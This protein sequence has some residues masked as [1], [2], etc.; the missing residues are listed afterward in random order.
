[1]TS[2]QRHPTFAE[3]SAKT[4][5]VFRKRPCLLQIKLCSAFLRGSKNIICSAATGFGKTLTFFMPLL[6]DPRIIIIITPLNV[7]GR[8]NVEQLKAA[9]IKAIS[10]SGATATPEVFS[11]IKAGAYQL[12]VTNPEVLMKGRGQFDRLFEDKKFTSK[13]MGFIADEAHCITKWGSFR[14][15]Y[16]ELG[17]LRYMLPNV[18]VYA[19]SATISQQ[20]LADLCDVLHL[21]KDNTEF[22][23]RS[24]DRLNVFYV[25]REMKHS[26]KSF[27]DLNFLI[28]DGWQEGNSPPAKFLVFFDNKKESEKACLHLKN[29]LPVA[30]RDKVQWFHANMTEK[31]REAQVDAMRSGETWGLC[32]T[33]SF[34]MG[35]DIPGIQLAVQYRLTCTMDSLMQPEVKHFDH[36][37]RRREEKKK[38][39]EE[40]QKQKKRKARS[41]PTEEPTPK[42][43]QASATEGTLGGDHSAEIGHGGDSVNVTADNVDDVS[44]GNE[45]ESDTEDFRS[46]YAAWGEK[47]S[48]MK[49]KEKREEIEPAMDDFVNA[50]ERRALG[51]RRKVPRFYFY[52]GKL[53]EDHHDCLPTSPAGC[54]RCGPKV[55]RLCCDLCNPAAIA[56]ILASLMRQSPPSE[57]TTQTQARSVIRK[58]EKSAIDKKLE[59]DL[60]LWRDREAQLALSPAHYID[61]GPDIFLPETVVHRIINC[62]HYGKIE[63]PEDVFRET[64]WSGSEQYSKAILGILRAA[65]PLP[66]L[67]PVF[68]STPSAPFASLTSALNRGQQESPTPTRRPIQCSAC[69]QL[70]H[71]SR[72]VTCPMKSAL[73]NPGAPQEPT[74]RNENLFPVGSSGS[75]PA[76]LVPQEVSLLP[77]TYF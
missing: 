36:E 2:T 70:G 50:G 61:F 6:F 66:A 58:Y 44:S 43:N 52:L 26:A 41:Q 48:K 75:V 8:Q 76:S 29:R 27:D 40:K 69:K 11:A 20:T 4:F 19:T 68:A 23:H 46:K 73:R 15:E 21:R 1:M 65:R 74:R 9:G 77:R 10:L 67:T 12:I 25:V 5:Q 72:N 60:F 18:R 16:R 32:V 33:D 55:S 7:L 35:I 17:L 59:D 64:R 13:L 47:Q 31:F 62:A 14:P 24:N 56:E 34:G 3:I 28:P 49:G 42:R 51:C 39:D 63:N 22:L 37:R 71:S 38:R 30:F 53:I 54:P 57:S 45:G